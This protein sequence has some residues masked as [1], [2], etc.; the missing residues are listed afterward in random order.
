MPKRTPTVTEAQ[1]EAPPLPVPRH[2][3]THT[4]AEVLILKCVERSGQTYGGFQWPLT[5]GAA[6]AAPDWEPTAECGHGL[7]GWPWG[8]AIGDGKEPEWAAT[9]LVFGAVPAE[10]VDLGGKVKAKAGTVRYVGDWSGALE[11]ILP[12]QMAWVHQA[13][14]GAASATGARGAASATGWMGAASATGE[15]GAAS[16]TGWMGTA[17]ATGGASAAVVTGRYGQAQCGPFGVLALA[18]YNQS[19]NRNEMRCARVGVGDGSDGT[20][21]A[22]TWYQLT[23]T[24]EFME[25][26]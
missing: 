25:A 2:Q 14:M 8:F 7:H 3:W 21:K 1:T 20:L 5:A 11:F 16:A 23:E 22:N 24:G 18:F 26:K 10:V 9:W 6:V 17:S 12:G 19:A 15:S 4:G 13:A